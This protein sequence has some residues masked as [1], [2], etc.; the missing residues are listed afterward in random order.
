MSKFPTG[1]YLS[2][3]QKVCF[4]MLCGIEEGAMALDIGRPR[5]QSQLCHLYVIRLGQ[6]SGP[7]HLLTSKTV[8]MTLNLETLVRTH[9]L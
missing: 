3:K 8:V 9:I 2:S 1:R 5:F 6:L 7:L 4:R